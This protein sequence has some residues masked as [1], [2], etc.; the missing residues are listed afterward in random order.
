[1]CGGIA[2]ESSESLVSLWVGGLLRLEVSGCCLQVRA[3]LEEGM[4]LLAQ[5]LG[6]DVKMNVW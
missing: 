1:M 2:L 6:N 5:L 3:V 4:A